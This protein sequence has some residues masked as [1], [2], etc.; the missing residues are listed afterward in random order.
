ML[1]QLPQRRPRPLAARGHSHTHQ[2]R[3]SR[4]RRLYSVE[5]IQVSGRHRMPMPAQAVPRMPSI[6]RKVALGISSTMSRRA[7]PSTLP[8]RPTCESPPTSN[9]R[10][11]WMQRNLL[12][13]AS[14]SMLVSEYLKGRP[15]VFI[16][17]CDFFRGG[18]ENTIGKILL[19]SRRRYLEGLCNPLGLAYSL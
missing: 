12:V 19:S 2:L 18:P 16:N 1:C 9:S 11:L 7:H 14:T 13:F 4:A 17:S 5:H 3:H 10:K 15:L 8:S 6:A